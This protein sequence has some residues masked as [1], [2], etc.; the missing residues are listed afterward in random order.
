MQGYDIYRTYLA[1][2]KHFTVEN[3]D[4]FK[5]NGKTRVSLDTY[6]K[7]SDF[8]FFETLSRK[9]NDEEVREYLLSTFVLSKDTSKVW[10]GDIKTNGKSNWSKWVKTWQSIDYTFEQEMESLHDYMKEND[11]SFDGIFDCSDGHPHLLKLHI[12]GMLCIETMLILDICMGYVVRWDKVLKDPLWQGIS[13][14]IRKYKPFV[15]VSKTKYKEILRG[16]FTKTR[17]E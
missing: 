8:Y 4:F 12:R 13:M 1:T 6:K 2:K 15:S 9:L 14:K 11:Y 7:R 5:Y 16:I 3:F 17:P 10:I